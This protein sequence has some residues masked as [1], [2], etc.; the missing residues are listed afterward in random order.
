MK[1]TILLIATAVFLT[2]GSSAQITITS[3][4][5]PQAGYTYMT[6]TDTTPSISLGT[7]G[8]NSQNWNFSALTPDYPSVPTFG[9]TSTTSYASIFPSSNLFTY[10][11]AAMF[12]GIYGGAPVGSQGMGKG[13]M[14]WK[15]DITGYRIVGFRADS[16][17]YAGINVI[18]NPQEL[19]I[20]TPATYNTSFS[21]TSRWELPI[22][23]VNQADPDT[24]YVSHT[25]KTLTADAWGSLTTPY[26]TFNS[27]LRVHEYLIKTDSAYYKSGTTVVF[28]ME[29][30]RD[31]SNNYLYLANGINYPAARVHATKN[32]TVK[33]V[34]YYSGFLL[35]SINDNS[36][37]G[38]MEV[39]NFPNPF[40]DE[41][42]LK[43]MDSATGITD[44][45]LKIV[46]ALGKE[47]SPVVIRNSEGFKIHRGNLSAGFY[48]YKV[49]GNGDVLQT[50]KIIV[51]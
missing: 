25:T 46:D 32:N 48:L 8:A 50:G 44:L 2:E 49:L 39:R 15:T 4:D 19:L 34:E 3:A 16:G 9:L 24:F 20:G 36:G 5:L 12:G 40:S 26:S 41:T 22:G 1:K 28:S 51:Q 31:T 18:E 23:N 45:Q 11:P 10:G 13:H 30:M 17:T 33:N 43:L 14:F 35:S 42:T 29:L 27:V 37:N 47:V 7:P 6:Y 21:N 38:N